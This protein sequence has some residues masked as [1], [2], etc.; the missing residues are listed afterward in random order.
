MLGALF[1]WDVFLVVYAARHHQDMG[2]DAWRIWVWLVPVLGT[3]SF[4]FAGL[5]WL[6]LTVMRGAFVLFDDRIAVVN[7][8]GRARETPWSEVSEVRFVK[9]GGLVRPP[10]M[11]MRAGGH[12]QNIWAWLVDREALVEAI[13][14]TA[15]LRQ[16]HDSWYATL[17][18]REVNS[19]D[20]I[21][22]Y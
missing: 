1:L 3:G 11:T 7:W 8:R 22:N 6:I 14:V 15:G 13:I 10:I 19:G 2:L 12:S 5:I 18:R 17:Y 16:S 21:L 9:C 20:T 4:V